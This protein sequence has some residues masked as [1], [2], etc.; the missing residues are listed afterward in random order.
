MKPLPLTALLWTTLVACGPLGGSAEPEEAAGEAHEEEGEHGEHAMGEVRLSPEA[1]AA[2]RIVVA[3]AVEGT[4]D[5][6]L[7]LPGRIAL[8][9]RKEAIVSAWTSGQVTAI[10]A[11]TGDRVKKGQV[12]AAVLSP[13]VAEASAAWRS[14]KARHD[15]SDARLER[16]K[17]LEEAGVASRSQVLEAEAAH[18]EAEGALESAEARLRIY[19]VTPNDTDM[20]DGGSFPS[21]VPVTS[22]IAGKVLAT[23][24]AVGRIVEP[25]DMLFHVGDLDEVWLLVDVY[26]RDLAH[27]QA[28]Q[29]VRFTVEAWPGEVFEGT[30]DQA[31]D[32]IEP[33]ARTVEVRVVVPNPGGRLKPNM[34]ASATLAIGDGEGTRGVVL[35]AAAVADIDGKDVVFV[36]EGDGVFEPR[37]VTVGDRTS[38][39]VLLTGGIAPGELVV[40]E[41]AFALK[42]EL[43]KSELGEGHGH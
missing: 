25:G 22:P 28:G 31:G 26:E 24:A 7:N 43:Q 34:F 5:T 29:P 1:L 42:G 38:T 4:L 41:G 23:E 10:R 12:L 18:A 9:P 27:V 14:A 2:A 21:E 19:G 32:W 13:E 30:I 3:P 17:R 33:E 11:R 20:H 6:E 8:D 39:E 40:T 37:P 16:L 36:Q 35:P 15:A